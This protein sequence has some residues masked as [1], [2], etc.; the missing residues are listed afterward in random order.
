ML[1]S[2]FH[3]ISL[4]SEAYASAES[5]SDQQVP[6]QRQQTYLNV[7]A[8][9]AVKQYLQWLSI[10]TDWHQSDSYDPAMR[11]FMDVADLTVPGYGRLECRPVLPGAKTLTIPSEVQS[12]RLGYIAVQFDAELETATLLGFTPTAT[13]DEILLTTLA[14]LETTLLEML[15]DAPVALSPT[16]EVPEELLNWQEPLPLG[17]WL[18]QT[19]TDGGKR[20]WQAISAIEPWIAPAFQPQLAQAVRGANVASTQVRRPL[21]G[22]GKLVDFGEGHDC[23]ALVMKLQETKPSET[24]IAVQVYPTG[25]QGQL[26]RDLELLILDE[27]GIAVMQAQSRRNKNIQMEFSGEPGETFSIKLALGKLSLTEAFQ[28]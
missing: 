12:D 11:R 2:P 21:A 1:S 15:G 25:E 27:Q 14:P 16:V 24:E 4:T 22:L 8:V 17:E 18:R 19:I 26:P 28:L 20:G 10:P 23:V 7:L 9:H 3:I 5:A 6:D 13:Q